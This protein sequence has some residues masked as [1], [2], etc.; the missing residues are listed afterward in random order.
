MTTIESP[1]QVSPIKQI[2]QLCCRLEKARQIVADGKVHRVLGHQ[3]AY[4]VEAKDGFYYINGICSCPDA[5]HRTDIHHGYCKHKLAVEL[6]K[7][8]TADSTP[9]TD[10]ELERK[11]AELY[12]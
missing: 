8:S 10:P 2:E 4:V 9:E 1:P 3:D 12:S 7:E 11:V 6:F 5:Q